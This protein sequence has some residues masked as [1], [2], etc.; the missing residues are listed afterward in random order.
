MRADQFS[1]RADND[2]AQLAAIRAGFGIGGLQLGIARRDKALIQVLSSSFMF[3]LEMWLAMHRD[4]RTNRRVRLVF[5]A[6]A[7]SL[8]EYVLGS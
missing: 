4:Q 5:D 6:L 1:L 3:S 7:L 2:L 8:A